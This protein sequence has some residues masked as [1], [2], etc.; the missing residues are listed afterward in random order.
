MGINQIQLTPELVTL[1]YPESLVTPSERQ[2]EAP[3]KKTAQTIKK[4]HTES[5]SY[6]FLGRNEKQVCFLVNHAGEDFL[7]EEQLVFLQ[8]ILTA[9][10][11][12]LDDIALVNTAKLNFDL[13]ELRVQFDPRIIFLWGILPAYV[14]LK[15]ALPDL[16]IY[17]LD[18][19]SI[20][21]VLSP[22]SMLRNNPEDIKY[23][24]SLWTSLKKLFN[25]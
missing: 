13:A 17:M 18:G 24:Q 5:T 16:S 12:S 21:P 2:E 19:I 20:V 10:K 3:S 7:P 15:L 8:K 25:L 6:P 9:C 14:G 4:V 1:L 11:F 23:K 22:E